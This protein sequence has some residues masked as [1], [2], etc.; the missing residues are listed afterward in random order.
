MSSVFGPVPSRRLG[1]SLGV[2]P[3]PF[4]VCSWSCGYCQ[5]GRTVSLTTERREWL[6]R[7]QVLADLEGTLADLGEGGVD[8]VTFA[9]SGEPTLHAGL[10]WL[11]RRARRITGLPLAVITNGALLHREDVRSELLEADA[12]LPTLDAG[13]ARVHRLMNRPHPELDFESHLRGLEA[14]RSAYK[15]LLWVEVMLVAGAND[16]AQDLEDLRRALDRVRPDA[17]HV[18]LPTR[19]PGDPGVRPPG[20]RS[21]ERARRILDALETA[22]PPAPAG[23]PPAAGLP[24]EAVVEL[25]Q[26]HPLEDR[27]LRR[28]LAGSSPEGLEAALEALESGVRIRKLDRDGR[29]CWVPARGRYGTRPGGGTGGTSRD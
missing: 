14:F 4:K 26:R 20:R 13:S 17:V 8:W 18:N 25:V 6:P 23:G 1:R 5:L 28:L 21:R 3:V 22:P 19:P 9:G 29:T 2:D 15:G 16:G 10:G 11:L 12:V 7:E 27:E 24:A